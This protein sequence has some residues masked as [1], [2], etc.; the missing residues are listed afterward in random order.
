MKAS[1]LCGAHYEGGEAHQH[2][3]WPTPPALFDPEVG[4]RS[5]DDFLAYAGL[6]DELGFDWVSVSEHHYS[7]L[8]LT[9]AVAPLAGALTQIVKRAKIALLGPLAPVNNPVRTAEEIAMLDQLSHGRL[10]VLP[11]RGTPNEFNCYVPVDPQ[12]TQSMTQEATLLIQKALSEPQP[13]AWDGEYYHFPTIAV[14]PRPVQRPFPPMYFSGNSPVS[15]VFAGAQRLGLCMSFRPPPAVAETVALY[16]AEAAKAGW[17]PAPDQIVYRTFIVVA[18]TAEEAATLE[19]NFV[20]ARLGQS[21][22]ANIQ[23]SRGADAMPADWKDGV[24]GAAPATAAGANGDGATADKPDSG[25]IG[26]GLGRLLF[27]GTPEVVVERIRA[28]H[29]ATGVG[30]LDF[31]FTGGQTPREAVRRSIEL[32]GREV[33]PRI[34]EIGEAAGEISGV[35]TGR[36]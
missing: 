30:V 29:E 5:Y 3:G 36:S 13:F 31:V 18:D 4:Q 26:F 11:L 22:A 9:P 17:Q 8:I 16:R 28:F 32:F 27:A 35:R 34:R 20:P 10:I 19:A 33:L 15:A 24:Q 7:P 14:W 1:F 23:A 6:A 21:I 12:Q 2:N 25:P